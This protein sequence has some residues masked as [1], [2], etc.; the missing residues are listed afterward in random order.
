MQINKK[1]IAKQIKEFRESLKISKAEM[2]RRLDVSAAHYLN[3]EAGR[4]VP[5]YRVV[6]T[7]FHM[8]LDV[9]KTIEVK[10]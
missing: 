5:S 7:L 9:A 10:K 8:G 3:Y 4:N 6:I 1:T 2:A